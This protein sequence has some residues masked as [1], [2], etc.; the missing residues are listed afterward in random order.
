M[1]F[2]FLSFPSFSTEFV[3]AHASKATSAHTAHNN[4]PL[5]SHQ[6]SYTI[7]A[8]VTAQSFSFSSPK[9]KSSQQLS[10]KERGRVTE[11]EEEALSETK[12]SQRS[13]HLVGRRSCPFLSRRTGNKR[14]ARDARAL[15][16]TQ[17]TPHALKESFLYKNRCTQRRPAMWK[18]LVGL[19][20][21]AHT[22]P[23]EPVSL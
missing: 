22:P 6:H 13:A 10:K 5:K 23:T 1:R 17:T 8:K 20:D 3:L 11:T 19:F 9:Q 4:P 15:A 7:S 18:Q 21:S 14:T 16:T 12:Q 2:I